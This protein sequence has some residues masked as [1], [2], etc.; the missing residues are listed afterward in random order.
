MRLNIQEIKKFIRHKKAMSFG[1]VWGRWEIRK[2]V[3]TVILILM[4]LLLETTTSLFLL[5]IKEATATGT[6]Y[7]V[8]NTITDTHTASADP[9][10][11][12]YNTVTYTCD[13]GTGTT[14][15]FAT[16]ADINAFSTLAA[17]DS[18]LFR[19]GQTWREQL[20]VPS[21]GSAGLP[22]TFGAYG[23]G[24]KPIIDNTPDLPGWGTAGNWTNVT[25]YSWT[26]QDSGFNLYDTSNYTYTIT[27]SI[28]GV[29]ASGSVTEANMK[30][31]TVAGTAFVDFSAVGSLT[32][33][34]GDLLVITD[35]LGKNITGY[36]KAAGTGETF[37]SEI[38]TNPSFDAN[39]TGWSPQDSTLA[40]IVGG[41]S[42][43]CLE[44]TRTVGSAQYAYEI[45]TISVGIL[46]KYSAYNKSGTSG[47]ETAQLSLLQYGPTY[48]GLGNQTFISADSWTQYTL[49]ATPS[50]AS[51][52]IGFLKNSATAGTML[53]D[54]ASVKQVLTPSATGVTIVSGV[55]SWSMSY[56]YAVSEGMGRT[57]LNTTEYYQAASA[58]AVDSTHR[59]YYD[60]PD[61]IF[62]IYA[63]SNPAAFYSSM[64]LAAIAS[65][66]STITISKDYINIDSLETRGRSYSI[67][68]S[69][70]NYVNISNATIG[71]NAINGVGLLGTNTYINIYNSTIESGINNISEPWNDATTG[72]MNGV[73][74][75]GSGSSKH[76]KIYNNTISNWNHAQVYIY[77]TDT[78]DNEV[79][80][81]TLTCP[82]TNYGRG[83]DVVGTTDN[84]VRDNKIY[85]NYIY[86]T[87]TYNGVTGN[88][89][90]VYYNI[91]DTV[92]TNIE[93][94]TFNGAFHF[95]YATAYADCKV[96]HDNLLYNN[97]VY[98]VANNGVQ[99]HASAACP[100]YNNII[101]N[102]IFMNW[103]TNTWSTPS[104]GI[105]AEDAYVGFNTI[106][107]NLFYKSGVT[108][109]IGW[110]GTPYTVAEFE[111]A[112]GAGWTAAN[113]KNANPLF[114]STSDF[115]LQSTSPAIN[116]GTNVSL[117]SDY[118]GVFVPR[119]LAQEIGAYEYPVPLAPTIGAPSAQNSS[120]IRWLFADNSND[121][122]QFRVYDGGGNIAT[123]SA[124]FVGISYLDE[125]GL[126]ENTQYT[127]RYVTAYNSYGNSASSSVASSK[128]TLADTPTN[129]S[130]T[131]GLT[132]MDLSVDAFIN[133]TAGSSGYYFSRSGANS[134]WTTTNSWSDTGLTCGTSY[135]YSV[136]Y[137]NGDG[138]VTDSAFLTKSTNG[139]PGGGTPVEW[140][141]P[142]KVPIN[143]FGILINNG[144]ESS[145]ISTVT[146]N[147]TGGSDTARMAISNFSDFRD[148]GQ[149]KYIS[150]KVWNLCWNNSILQTPLTCP[151]GTYTVYAKFYTSWGS[152]SDV[153]S[154]TIV[155]Q[156][157]D[158]SN[159]PPSTG[160]GIL[161]QYPNDP[162]IYLI[163]EG[164]KHWIK[165][166]QTF[167]S[168]NLKWSDIIQVP[169]TQTYPDGETI[170]NQTIAEGGLIRAKDSIDV[171][172]VKYVGDK[173]FKRLILNPTVFTS[174]QHLKWS[175][176]KIVSQATMDQFTTS[177]LA[178]ALGDTKVYKLSS[179]PNA[180]DG[181]KQWLNMSAEA[182]TA[183][184]YDWDSIYVINDVDRDNYT[185]GTDITTTVSGSV[186]VSLASDTPAAGVLDGAHPGVY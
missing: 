139:C 180:D 178:R 186:T 12:T 156:L 97:V 162:R 129:L 115:H 179:A 135:T 158:F 3:P 131:A 117:T 181:Q 161:I 183:A 59:W 73:V 15:A 62:Y 28:L 98:N 49:Y 75:S 87:T 68:I 16:I 145:T 126:L 42:N 121:E 41:Q 134:G 104:Y 101:K 2:R 85:G 9:D 132:T 151:D 14:T 21:S 71:L 70:A 52:F 168:L 22:I 65:T 50:T 159:N 173:S 27:D 86:D 37:G 84:A 13:A 150:S 32:P 147:L 36:I 109:V 120:S 138:I 116:T 63:T 160:Q 47:N 127:G 40:S 114:V 78:T 152:A 80:G 77:G 113:N 24:A 56:N 18:V 175:N 72:G 30:L 64:Q 130:G 23:S 34:L 45:K 10:C 31:S 53:F 58:A 99:L 91:V 61:N 54:E 167:N 169:I 26:S 133:A 17:G 106:S 46:V 92:R 177:E 108:D 8:D 96:S 74:F 89:N 76:C 94:A 43:N 90:S 4:L 39:T 81:N 5:P 55:T 157:P 146:L 105:S 155:L 118:A 128:Y 143:G 44:I 82:D 111:A 19:K 7:Y 170:Q 119:G 95:N 33:Y 38:L 11:D 48:L 141:N 66:D 176:L 144:A 125:T 163:Q 35:S 148:A 20:T 184:G 25:T 103:E 123:S 124:T 174:Y 185:T 153:V 171:Y 88:N 164:Q 172:V 142:P 182:F 140:N 154:D 100:V 93:S 122:T 1:R 29:V 69:G 165:D 149:E 6:T 57:F 110:N 60:D 67:S 102:N 79:Y 112:S 136:I 51:T 137:R 83:F 107:N 166:I